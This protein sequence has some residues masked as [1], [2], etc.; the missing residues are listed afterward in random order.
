MVDATDLQQALGRTVELQFSD[1][2]VVQAELLLIVLHEPP[3]MV[4]KVRGIAAPVPSARSGL[5]VTAAV[6]EL[7]NWRLV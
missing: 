2:A 5:V 4:Y 6:S 1:G 7:A 3:R